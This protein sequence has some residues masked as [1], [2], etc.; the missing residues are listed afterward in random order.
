ME[1]NIDYSGSNES[2]T[3]VAVVGVVFALLLLIVARFIKAKNQ[4][5]NYNNYNQYLDHILNNNLE[6]CGICLESLN[7]ANNKFIHHKL[8]HIIS[9]LKRANGLNLH[10]SHKECITRWTIENDSCPICRTNDNAGNSP[11]DLKQII[12]LGFEAKLM[13]S[14]MNWYQNYSANN[15]EDQNLV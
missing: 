13:Q 5:D 3:I 10:I 12:E 8:D 14:F 15:I 7:D 2:Q 9:D 1:K 11:I 4:L 6:D